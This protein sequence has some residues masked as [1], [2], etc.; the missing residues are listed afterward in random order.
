MCVAHFRFTHG[1]P[2]SFDSV[3]LKLLSQI[4]GPLQ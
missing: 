4:R 3:Q 2:V 1:L